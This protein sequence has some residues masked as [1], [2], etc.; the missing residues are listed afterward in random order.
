MTQQ[1]VQGQCHLIIAFCKGLNNHWQD[2]RSRNLFRL[3]KCWIHV[4]LWSFGKSRHDDHA[5][6]TRRWIRIS[7]VAP[8]LHEHPECHHYFLCVRVTPQSHWCCRAFGEK[9]R[10]L[11][12]G[13]EGNNG[14]SYAAKTSTKSFVTS[15][16]VL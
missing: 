2:E 12:C 3:H 6:R 15:P 7:S 9:D 13:N 4:C 14:F 8:V 10:C 16:K 11:A 1:K 5:V